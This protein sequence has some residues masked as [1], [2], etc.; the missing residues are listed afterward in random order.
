MW[1]ILHCKSEV[2]RSFFEYF[3]S[4][5]HF[6][7]GPYA[8]PSL[9][10]AIGTNAVYPAWRIAGFVTLLWLERDIVCVFTTFRL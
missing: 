10:A 7:D 5:L 1:V 2:T 6:V 9:Q 4:V 3:F 8:L